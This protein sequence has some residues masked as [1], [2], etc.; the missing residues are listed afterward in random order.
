MNVRAVLSRLPVAAQVIVALFILG[1]GS[2]AAVFGMSVW[3]ALRRA[4]HEAIIDLRGQLHLAQGLAGHLVDENHRDELAVLLKSLAILAHD[5]VALL[6]NDEGHVVENSDAELSRHLL[7][8]PWFRRLTLSEVN[9]VTVK[10]WTDDHVYGVAPICKVV[11]G[12]ISE[13]KCVYLLVEHGTAWRLSAATF[14]ELK[15]SAA[16]LGINVLFS[17]LC[18][19]IINEAVA[20]PSQRIIKSILR[21]RGGDR[22]A[23]CTLAGSDELAGISLAIDKAFETITDQ[24]QDLQLLETAVSQ[25]PA[26]IVLIDAEGIVQFRNRAHQRIHGPDESAITALLQDGRLRSEAWSGEF[27]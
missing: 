10:S 24:Q 7:D 3:D 6:V 20:K 12:T 17:L 1:L 26:A 16:V 25:S 14:A 9:S 22:T 23:R 21:F 15:R 5:D 8:T 19:W 18:W 4:Q 27:F 2:H 13:R 11:P